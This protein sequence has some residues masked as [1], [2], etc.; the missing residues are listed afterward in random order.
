[1]TDQAETSLSLFD[2]YGTPESRH[3]AETISFGWKVHVA[4]DPED[5]VRIKDRV[6]GMLKEKELFLLK[7][8]RNRAVLESMRGTAQEGKALTLYFRQERI[9]ETV[10]PVLTELAEALSGLPPPKAVIRERRFRSSPFLYYRY[11]EYEAKKTVNGV[12]A[13]L[14]LGL[15]Y[16]C[17]D[18]QRWMR[19]LYGRK[20]LVGPGNCLWMDRQPDQLHPPWVSDPFLSP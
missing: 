11:G 6:C 15:V 3:Q 18:G 20:W 2:F 13:D 16:T 4:C 17:R 7:A 5:L 12:S 9:G 1:M 14:T 19:D 10:I 8:V